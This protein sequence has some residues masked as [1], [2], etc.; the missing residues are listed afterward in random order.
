MPR[1]HPVTPLCC[2][3]SLARGRC[4]CAI[5]QSGLSTTRGP[6]WAIPQ[7]LPCPP[8]GQRPRVCPKREKEGGA[9]A[10]LSPCLGQDGSRDRSCPVPGGTAAPASSPLALGVP[11]V[12]VVR[13][14]RPSRESR[15]GPGGDTVLSGQGLGKGLGLLRPLLGWGSRPGAVTLSPGTPGVPGCPLSPLRPGC[16]GAPVMPA[17]PGGPGGPGRP[18]SPYSGEKKRWDPGKWGGASALSGWAGV[19]PGTWTEPGDTGTGTGTGT[20]VTFRP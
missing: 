7:T 8:S 2:P 5:T 11:G 20:G 1:G 3:K 16:P 18:M 6:P 19:A 4:P 13:R 12:L 14:H 10:P 9:R 15:S 17:E